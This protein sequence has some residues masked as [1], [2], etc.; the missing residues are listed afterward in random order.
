[1]NATIAEE[2]NGPTPHCIGLLPVGTLVLS[3]LARS[4]V[5]LPHT[6]IASLRNVT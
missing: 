3:K 2:L 5:V 4:S 1:M 6:G